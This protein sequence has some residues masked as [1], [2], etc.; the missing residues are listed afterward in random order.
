[1]TIWYEDKNPAIH[2]GQLTR[3]EKYEFVIH[4]RES[5]TFFMNRADGY[6]QSAYIPKWWRMT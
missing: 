3:Y 6:W 2:G 4:P 5:R 1:M